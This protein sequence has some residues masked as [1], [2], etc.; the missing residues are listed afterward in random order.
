MET[1][2]S[3]F[4]TVWATREAHNNSSINFKSH[5]LI[6]CTPVTCI[7]AYI[8]Y[9]LIKKKKLYKGKNSMVLMKIKRHD[10]CEVLSQCFE[11]GKKSI[12]DSCYYF[13]YPITSH[14]LLSL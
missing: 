6:Y 7:I 10:V 9:T 14:I 11:Q 8:K 3:T 4:L 5:E 13:N 12:N 2:A 1:V